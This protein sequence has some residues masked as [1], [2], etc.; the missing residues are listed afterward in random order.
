LAALA[1][2]DFVVLFCEATP[3]RLIRDLKPDVLIKGADW[4]GKHVVGS[5]VVEAYGGRVEFI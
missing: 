3:E 4:K 2:V 5:D 1:C